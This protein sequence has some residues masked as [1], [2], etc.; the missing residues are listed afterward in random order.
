MLDL[1]HVVENLDDVR[2]QLGRRSA[3]HAALLD[4]IADLA[5]RRL[6]VIR[7]S[8]AKAAEQPLE[9]LVL[10]V[11]VGQIGDA[12]ELGHAA[13]L[14][15][16]LVSE[17]IEGGVQLGHGDARLVSEIGKVSHGAAPET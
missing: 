6:E 4:P 16:P 8:E 11:L 10:D 3:A 15:L 14:V 1:R 7:T 12:V 5:G 13:A 2:N 17:I 9:L